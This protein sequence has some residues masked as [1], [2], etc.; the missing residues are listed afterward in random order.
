LECTIRQLGSGEGGGSKKALAWMI[1]KAVGESRLFPPKEVSCVKAIA[2]ELPS[3]RKIPLS[4]FSLSELKYELEKTSLISSIST[5][6]IWRILNE[7][8]IRPWYH[9]S[10]I[11][12]RDPYFLEKASPVLDLYQRIWNGK[13][14]GED[15]YVISADEKT[16]IQALARSHPTRPPNPGVVMQVEDEYGRGGVVAYMAALDVFSGKVFGTVE[17]KTGIRPFGRLIDQVMSQ[18]PYASAKRVFWIVD[19]GSSHH[20][21]TFPE[22]LSKAYGNAIAVHLPLHAS[23]LNQIELYFSILQRK[24]LTPNDFNNVEDLTQ[25]LLAFQERYNLKAC[26]FSWKFTKKDLQER[27]RLAA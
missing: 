25:R 8:A 4:R 17:L 16:Q 23:W 21:S 27:L 22:R 12:P 18:E 11:F 26:P 5:T 7:D 10:W 1:G 19:N 14:L 6:T 20:P 13:P 24:A 3:K 2:C 15:V 9:Q